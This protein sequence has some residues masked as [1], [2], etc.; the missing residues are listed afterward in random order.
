MFLAFLS[1]ATIVIITP[2][3]DTAVTIRN[4]LF[5]GR[6]G[7]IM[8]ALGVASG[9]AIWALATSAGIVALLLA[10]DPIF[11]AIKYAGAAYLVF[12]GL[13]ALREAIRPSATA[14]A[15]NEERPVRILSAIA[16]F[17]QGIVSNL[18]N[19][20][21][22]V[23]FASL[24]PHFVP[25]ESATFF[26]FFALGLMFALMTLAWLILY[27]ILVSR[28]GDLLR[29]A[30]VRRWIEG[31]TGSVLIGLGVMVAVEQR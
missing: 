23:F 14:T 2:G 7:G 11:L 30:A 24:L 9:Q 19:P 29:R 16:A 22:A 12:L 10:S 8:T 31:A 25:A 5:A 28:I 4:T 18:G 27:T 26:A 21:M 15:T 17:R 1:V 3:P 13:Q 20:K 6:A